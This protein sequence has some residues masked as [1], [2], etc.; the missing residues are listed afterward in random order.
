MIQD[1]FNKPFD[2]KNLKIIRKDPFNELV[3]EF[4]DEFSEKLKSDK[5]IYNFPDLMYLMFWTRKKELLKYKNLILLNELRVG[6][7]LAFHICPSNV[8][9]NFF[10][11]F[12][13]GLLSG[14]SNIIKMPS[15][16]SEQKK[17]YLIF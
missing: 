13:F 7:G 11:S 5:N 2:I 16:H 12:I 10:Y 15:I 4:L 9:T 3:I 8:P 1:I 17:L 6:R 14:N